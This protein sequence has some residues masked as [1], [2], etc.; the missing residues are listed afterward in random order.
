VR[1]LDS[2]G[3]ECLQSE[4]FFLYAE[5]AGAM[6]VVWES[7]YPNSI[8]LTAEQ[9][10]EAAWRLGE[11]QRERRKEVRVM[12]SMGGGI[13]SGSGSG[14]AR[15]NDSDLDNSGLDDSDNSDDDDDEVEDESA[16][17]GVSF[18]LFTAWFL[19][20]LEEIAVLRRVDGVFSE[21]AR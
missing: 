1:D 14:G 17:P 3:A 20:L 4:E 2:I 9:Q 8:C 13:G 21:E 19:S 15:G 16:P 11:W 18:K 5:L 12:K 10:T 6:G 7:F